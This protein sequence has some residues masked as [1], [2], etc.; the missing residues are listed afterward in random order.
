MDGCTW[1]QIHRCLHISA[2]VAYDVSLRNA[3][4]LRDLLEVLTAYTV[5]TARK[6]IAM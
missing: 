5:K 2:V 4:S 1:R 3:L 6:L